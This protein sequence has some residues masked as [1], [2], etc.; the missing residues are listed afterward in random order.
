MISNTSIVAQAQSLADSQVS[1]LDQALTQLR[2]RLS[3][4]ALSENLLDALEQQDKNSITRY[5]EELSRAFPEAVS[6]KLIELG[7]L[8]IA[9]LNKESRKLRNNIELDLLRHVS[10]GNNVEP[11]AYKFEGKWLFSLAEP[12]KDTDKKYA[13]A[14]ILIT[15]DEQYLRTLFGQLDNSL[16]QTQ[17]IQQFKNKRHLITSTGISGNNDFL[18]T[19]EASVSQ[20]QLNFTP[21]AEL[22]AKSGHSANSL[23]LI[24]GVALLATLVAAANAVI[25]LQKALAENLERLLKA[26]TK[27]LPDFNLPGFNQAA[28]QLKEKLSQSPE[29]P[30]P[31]SPEPAKAA[32]PE[33]ESLLV[34]D[35]IEEDED[36]LS[37]PDHLPEAI[38]RAYDIRGLADSELTDEVVY[39]I[40]LAVGSEALDQGQQS[41]IVA[42]DGRHS[43]PRIRDA[44]VKGLTASGRD[45]IDIGTQPTPLMY[46]ATHQLGTQSGVMITGSHNPSEYNGIKIVIG[47]KALSGAAISSLKERINTNTLAGGRGQY[48]AQDIEQSYID[49]IINDV[50]IAQP[51]KIVLDAGNGVAGAIAPQLFEE[52]GCEVI[53][54][55][56]EVDGDFPNHHPDPT[57][58]ANL[59]DLKK[60][61]H[62]QQADLGIAFDGDGDRLGVV[63]ASGKSVP[64]DRLLML[65]AQDV[66]S[67]NPGADVLFDVKCTRNLNTLISN[68]GGRPIMWKTG[69][70]FMKEKMAE[71]GALLGGEFSGHIFF[72]ERWFGFD[73]GMYAAARLIEILSTTDP[74]LDL[75]LEA[76]PESIGSP[77]LKVETTESQKF[78]IIEQLVSTA[79]FEDGK[80]STLDGLR[81]DFP[82]GWGLV[83]A[84]NTTP[85][86]ILRFEA[87][88]DEAMAR[89]QSQFKDQ[90][91]GIDNSLQFGF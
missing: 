34:L 53:P 1:L 60:H 46:F 70:S 45:V 43:S 79:Q 35:E 71:T 21:S 67:R 85:M 72:K 14:A 39:A 33:E 8:G 31:P 29:P 18:V 50:A 57:V 42:A 38:F 25:T 19:A 65:L 75:Q 74:D 51:L 73:D 68:Y 69:H 40:G 52:L 2:L 54:L 13:S 16:G 66:V 32:P 48:Q 37:L 62:E 91:A 10:N 22:V 44:L 89:I 15:L 77:E 76:F 82:D 59:V 28:E 64:A 58:E 27:T 80:I 55:Y 88:T 5:R 81:V 78:V 63:T 61:V 84:S 17:L 49:Y 6:V 7:P 24:M 3:N 83:R 86:L 36:G 9:S 41:V 87:D 23:W 56:C 11:E 90:L 47:G 30:P 12:V 4:I 26:K 20:W